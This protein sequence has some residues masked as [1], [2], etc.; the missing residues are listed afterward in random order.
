[1]ARIRT[2]KPDLFRHEALFEAE[3]QSG[4]PLRLAFIGL[5]TAC[6]REGRFRW[7]P[8][9]IKLD[10]MPYDACDF[11][12]VLD[13]LASRGF[14]VRYAC[15]DDEYGVIPSWPKHQVI[16]NREKLSV[17]PGVD[18][19]SDVFQYENNELLARGER[20]NDASQ[21]RHGNAQGEGKG[22]E[23]EQEGKGK[24]NGTSREPRQAKSSIPASEMAD[25]LPGLS[26]EAAEEYRSYR[27]AKKAPL[28]AGAWKTIAKE[29]M[30]SGMDPVE[31]IN[32]AMARN[33]QGFE[34]SWLQQNQSR[35][36]PLLSRQQQVEEA[37]QRVVDEMMAQSGKAPGLDF[38][39]SIT[40]DGEVI[41]VD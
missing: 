38:G 7:Q 40:I 25:E 11:S 27:K 6:D 18:E 29:I 30:K 19:A 21:S 5:F 15:G 16:N 13:A 14:L 3:Q 12:R 1:M 28:T 37:N 31:A 17:Y 36:A 26:I 9:Q 2:V 32:T 41:H 4:L 34:A 39:Q 35:G 8:R 33:W 24:G 10:V 22:R 20:V 23:G